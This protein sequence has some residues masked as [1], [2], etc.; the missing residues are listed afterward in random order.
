MLR[1]PFYREIVARLTDRDGRIDPETFERCAADLLRA[2]YPR[3]VPVRGGSDAGMDGAVAD[4]RGPP[5]PLICTTSDRVAENVRRS[6]R[7]H[8]ADGGTRRNAVV[9]TSRPLTPKRRAN[10]FRLAAEEGFRLVQVHDQA[11]FADLLYRSPS[12]CRE[13]LGL[14]SQPPALSV[15]PLSSRP[16]LGAVLVGRDPELE[17]LGGGAGDALLVGQPGAGKT[18][19]LR[20]LAG[21]GGGL[22]V[23][24]EDPGEIAAAIR[25]QA[26]AALFVDD[27][28]RRRDLLLR[29][30]HMRNEI[31]AD[32]RILASCWPGERSDVA[33]TL[34]L[35]NAAVRELQLLTRREIAEVIQGC[36]IAGPRPL[37][38]ELIDQAAGK[39]GLAVTLASLCLRDGV[40][41]LAS[42]AAL[43]E[44]V[45]HTFQGLVGREA[46]E[47]LAGFSVG[48]ELGMSMDTVSTALGISV[49]GLRHAVE[50]LAAGGVLR[51]RSDGRLVVE[52][53]ALRHALI[54]AV[55]FCGAT[56]LPIRP[57]LAVAPAPGVSALTLI[58]ARSRGAAVPDSL[59]HEL[60]FSSN[61][62]RAWK[63]YASLGAEASRWVLEQRPG[64]LPEIAWIALHTVPE[65]ATPRLL[66]LAV[67]D[68]R[69]LSS[70]PEHPLR[71]LRDW[72]RAGVPGTG[73]AVARREQLLGGVLA[74]HASGR[75]EPAVCLRAMAV[76]FDP[77]FEDQEGDPVEAMGFTLRFGGLLAEEIAA[78]S[79]LWP[80]ALP[81]LRACGLAHWVALREL[82]RDWAYPGITTRGKL[83]PGASEP[84][85]AL[86]R[87]ITADVLEISGGHAGVAGWIAGFV[88]HK[89]WEIP[90][91]VDPVFEVLFP[92]RDHD[93]LRE[94]APRQIGAATALAREWTAAP[95]AVVAARIVTCARQAEGVG[96][97]WPDWTG[98]VA[99]RLAEA[100]EEP[101]AWAREM[102]AAGNAPSVVDPFLRRALRE[103]LG[104]V[105][106]LWSECAAHPSLRRLAIL[107][108]LR[109]PAAPERLVERAIS[110]LTGLADVIA[111]EC[112]MN[113]LP[114]DRLPRLLNHPDVVVAERT[115]WAIWHREP[116]GAVPEELRAG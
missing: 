14:T 45:R 87:R 41:D 97:G 98:H 94:G 40:G 61:D 67:G 77:R 53:D 96:H 75:A 109:E 49:L 110:D 1:D 31:G 29:L 79:A 13:L 33:Q 111:T 11:A 114:E 37:L 89:G 47:I 100:A 2:I 48:G 30:R 70:H 115:A 113:H 76:A 16:L 101:V 88:D 72:V 104:D 39:P 4:G 102:I 10:L 103:R 19:V 18:H 46:V 81:L 107:A 5:F 23:T 7:S 55:F 54:G 95:P 26:P 12:W 43:F 21:R 24:A 22:F 57:F 8:R 82:I 108:A 28:H 84:M 112:E 17:W 9:A 80:R 59:L 60:L 86:A 66:T 116:M 85:Q 35:A 65:I 74:W 34:G 68:D 105:E 63:E 92:Q 27:A 56:S 36:G 6:M 38:K 91:P 52:P 73:E 51:E 106:A 71:R 58:G 64:L 44:D 32:F 69:P 83:Q 62:R 25:A 99:S 50:R 3:L 90:V 15:V 78:V 42:G 20:T 93:D